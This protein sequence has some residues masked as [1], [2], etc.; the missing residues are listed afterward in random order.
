MPSFSRLL[1]V[2]G[3]FL[4]SCAAY[5]E[6]RLEGAIVDAL[7]KLLGPA[8]RYEA[9][10]HGVDATGSH[11]DAVRALG[12]RVQRPRSPVLDRIE[13]EL[14]DVAFD[15]PA[16][17]VTSVGT[18]KAT[19]QLRADDLTAYLEKQRWIDRPT[20]RFVAPAGIVVEARLQLPGL[21]LP[22][23]FGVEFRGRL[24]PAESKLLLA[25][26]GLNL[27]DRAAPWLARSL[28]EQ[29]INPLLDLSAH[30]LPARIDS[31]EVEGDALALRASGSRIALRRDA[32]R[33]AL[34]AVPPF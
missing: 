29:A 28:I 23:A 10:V 7:P 3:T 5:V 19:L 20:V 30:A 14:Q 4:V 1:L 31:V 32:R 33:D 34:P 24:I 11:I 18:A 27:G 21:A 13:V 26:D 25:V 22:A 9:S 16:K 6:Q 15:R 17:R 2:L 12:S 8:D